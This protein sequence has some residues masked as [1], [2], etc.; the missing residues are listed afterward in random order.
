MTNGDECGLPCCREYVGQHPDCTYDPVVADPRYRGCSGPTILFDRSHANFHQV[1]PESRLR[2]GRFWGFAKLLARDGYVVRDSPV[3]FATLLP[4]L[5]AKILVIANPQ[6]LIRQVAVP[7]AEVAAL[8]AWVEQGGSLL[9]SIDHPPFDR[10][11]DLMAA[12]GL[13]QFGGRVREFTFTVANGGVN[14]ASPITAGVD[15]VSTFTGTAV[16][17]A[18]SPPP[19]ATYEPVLTLPP[20]APNSADGWLQGVAIQFGAGRVYVS[21]ESGGLTAQN[22]FGMQET[23]DNER[24]VRNIVHWLDD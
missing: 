21:A 23:P 5:P 3:P 24:Y 16:R 8:A 18:P 14:A 22:T 10:T 20:G 11:D 4:D 6:S 9:L 15:E 7:P 2:P 12:F 13:E 19:Q 17:I 1:T